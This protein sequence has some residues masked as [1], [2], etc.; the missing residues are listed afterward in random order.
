MLHRRLEVLVRMLQH[1]GPRGD[2]QIGLGS[3]VPGMSSGKTAEAT[4]CSTTGSSFCG[5]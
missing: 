3:G 5:V 4:T 2:D 1:G